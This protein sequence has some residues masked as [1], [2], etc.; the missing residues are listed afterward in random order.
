M[1]KKI[2]DFE[3]FICLYNTQLPRDCSERTITGIW[4]CVWGDKRQTKHFNFL[5]EMIKE[6]VLIQDGFVDKNGWKRPVYKLDR[7]RMLE[8]MLSNE[9]YYD[10][11]WNIIKDSGHLI[12]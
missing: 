9:L 6:K 7:D 4:M 5:K 12:F 11:F 8:F 3:S 2:S 10:F 1:F